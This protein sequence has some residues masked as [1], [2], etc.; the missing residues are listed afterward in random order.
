[1]I[2]IV[3]QGGL[4][5]QLFQYAYGRALV[6]M[7]KEVE[8]DISFFENNTKY[9]KRHFSL[10]MFTLS[11]HIATTKKQH[12]QNLFTRILN[13]IDCDRKV[14]YV[15]VPKNADNYL[16]DGYYNTERYFKHIRE[17]V[18]NEV[19]LLEEGEEYKKWKEK[20]K[21]AKKSL[22]IHA[23]R[24]DFVGSGFVNLDKE[25]YEKALKE[26]NEDCDIFLF[27]DDIE[28]LQGV[29]ERSA[30]SVSGNGLKDYEEF[31]LMS[32]GENFI[33]A[34][35][36]FSWWGAWLSKAPNKKVIAPKKWFVS[37]FWSRANSDVVPED[38][39]RI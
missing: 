15:P 24:T 17:K 2:T 18:L 12:K 36:T 39:I 11:K 26:F 22:I 23:R 37:K 9:T 19:V 38:W 3:V 13:K 7:G 4:G 1:M 16:A 25:Y 33:I 28:W 34:N 10:D 8:F 32:L 35:S 5:N 6:E 29:V 30:T 21:G 27:S 14:R 20:I 31:M